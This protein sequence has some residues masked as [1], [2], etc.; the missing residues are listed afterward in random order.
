MY[1]ILNNSSEIQKHIKDL[2][3]S[4]VYSDKITGN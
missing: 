1:P 3:V 4:V 2:S